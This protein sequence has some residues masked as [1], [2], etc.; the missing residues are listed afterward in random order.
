MKLTDIFTENDG[1]TFCPGRVALIL[2]VLVFIGLSTYS[3]VYLAQKFDAMGY[4][5]GFGGLT[6][7]SLAG[8]WAKS[9][10]DKT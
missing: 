5:T 3:V 1:D 2:G 4:G 10:T 8:I 7:G 6:G 9:K